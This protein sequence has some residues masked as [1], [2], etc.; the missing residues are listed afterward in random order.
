MEN[1]ILENNLSAWEKKFCGSRVEIENK[2]KEWKNAKVKTIEV[3]TEI[4][5]DEK[6]ILIV[7]KNNQERYLAGKET[8]KIQLQYGNKHRDLQRKEQYF[9]LEG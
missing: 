6:V 2:Y 8:V 1:T 4:S 9:L 7:K 5:E 3:R